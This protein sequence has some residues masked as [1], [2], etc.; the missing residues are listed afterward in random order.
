MRPKFGD[1]RDRRKRSVYLS[2]WILKE[3]SEDAELYQ[4]SVSRILQDAW[5]IARVAPVQSYPPGVYMHARGPRPALTD[6]F[7]GATKERKEDDESAE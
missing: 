7:T 6:P 1:E 4:L 2:E 3:I 5:R